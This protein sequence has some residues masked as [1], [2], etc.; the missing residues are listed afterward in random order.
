MPLAFLTASE[1][2]ALGVSV[3]VSLLAVA[4]SLPVA[5][6]LGWLL[7]RREFRGKV[8]VETLISLPL[9]MPPVVTGYLL[10]VAFG[11]HGLLGQPLHDWFGIHIVFDWKGAAL[12]SAVVAF[13]LLV[14]PIRL[15][16]AS[17]DPRLS[18]AARTLGASRLDAFASITL[19]LA[20][21][22]IVAGCL[23]AFARSMGE[24]GATIMIAGSIPG[25]T[26][27]VPIYLYNLLQSPSAAGENDGTR[28]IVASIV[29]ALLA[30]LI[31]GWLER[32][33]RRRTAGGPTTRGGAHAAAR[34]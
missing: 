21:P 29:V 11:R 34:V 25:E 33:G 31:G 17:I 13:P 8:L 30:L 10:L 16:F 24:F 20:L 12:A 9:V 4:A 5:L 6:A 2:E 19:P 27:T 14:G 32:R 15:A 23:L 22:G 1:A 28:M 3:K 18:L 7:A 26:R